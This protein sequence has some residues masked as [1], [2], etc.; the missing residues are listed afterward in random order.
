MITSLFRKLTKA[1]TNNFQDRH[2][3]ICY[4]SGFDIKARPN[5]TSCKPSVRASRDCVELARMV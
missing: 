1:T 5:D 4:K 2:F 3:M